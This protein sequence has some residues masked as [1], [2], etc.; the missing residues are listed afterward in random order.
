MQPPQLIVLVS[1]S[2]CAPAIRCI[3]LWL[4][5]IQTCSY[6]FGVVKANN[7]E[8]TP[9]KCNAAISAPSGRLP[10]VVEGQ[11]DQS[12]RTFF[13]T[14]LFNESLYFTVTQPVSVASNQTGY[15]TIEPDQIKLD[16][17]YHVEYYAGPTDFPM[18]TPPL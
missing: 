13:I 9:V 14:R 10:D 18:F 1:P 16:Q 2:S 11:C 7:G 3:A 6:D 4:T 5:H 17:G 8:T 15:H 12:S